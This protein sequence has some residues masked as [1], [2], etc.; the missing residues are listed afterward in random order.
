MDTATTGVHPQQMLVAVLVPDCR[1]DDLYGGGDEAPA[2]SADIG[3]RAAG[4][5]G[6]VVGHIDIEDELA[7]LGCEVA[8]A[9]EFSVAGLVWTCE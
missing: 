8:G 7:F 9:E 3:A 1:V 6:V 2:S 5:D 4:A